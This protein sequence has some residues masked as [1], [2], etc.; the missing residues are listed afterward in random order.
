MTD[1]TSRDGDDRLHTSVDD[2]HPVAQ[3]GG[4]LADTSTGRTPEQVAAEHFADDDRPGPAPSRRAARIAG[5][6]EGPPAPAPFPVTSGRAKGY[7]RDA[8]NAFLEHARVAYE[9]PDLDPGFTS[10]AIREWAFPVSR[11]G[12][13]VGAVDAALGR[14]EDAFAARERAEGIAH[15]GV[16][17]WVTAARGSAQEIL[18]RLR[19]ADRHKF[20]RVG[21]M[22][23]GYRVDEVDL[24]AGKLAAYFETGQTISVEQ[25]RQIAFRMQRRGYDEAQVDAVL[26]GVVD[27]MLAVR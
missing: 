4:T 5:A 12:Y 3:H 8:V 23:F 2:P 19:R 20:R 21:M 22:R 10:S 24:V 27:V 7:D 13:A 9:D 16:D 25:V 17:A 1:T 14:I 6:D 26:D 18:D 11:H 15:G